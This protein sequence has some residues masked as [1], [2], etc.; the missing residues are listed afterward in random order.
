MAENALKL[1]ISVNP[2]RVEGKVVNVTIS[3]KI[4]G[5]LRYRVVFRKR[6]GVGGRL[7]SFN[8]ESYGDDGLVYACNG[9]VSIPGSIYSAMARRAYAIIFSEKKQSTAP[10]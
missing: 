9:N 5:K 2:K 1:E 6:R 8:R 7:E 3:A 10:T 4:E